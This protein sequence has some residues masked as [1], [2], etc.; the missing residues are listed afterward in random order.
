VTGTKSEGAITWA[1]APILGINGNVENIECAGSRLVISSNADSVVGY[2]DH[3]GDQDEWNIV[4]LAHAPSAYH[5]G[6]YKRTARELWLAAEDGYIYKSTG[7]GGTW[8]AMLEGGLTAENLNAIYAYDA[9]LVYAVGDHGVILRSTDGGETWQDVT[10]VATTA[11]NLLVVIVPPD[12]PREVYVGTND[13]R[14]YRSTDEGDTFANIAFDGDGVG[15]VDDLDFCGPCAGDVMFIL[16]NDAGPR[17]RIL[18]D[19]SGGAGGADVEIVMDYLDVIAT[20]ID[21]NALAC[22]SENE[23]VAAG[24]LYGGYPVVIKAS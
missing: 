18:R 23:L 21:L 11:A 13:G 5:T 15:T 4:A 16:H 24:E 17:A 8:T 12:R 20:G 22:C 6:L 19:L 9:D 14:I 1:V 10:E 7:G 3:D 2:N